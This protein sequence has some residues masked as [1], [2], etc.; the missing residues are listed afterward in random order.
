MAFLLLVQIGESVL[1]TLLAASFD[2]CI[3]LCSVCLNQFC[4]FGYFLLNSS[5]G[6]VALQNPLCYL[7]GR[8]TAGLRSRLL[9]HDMKLKVSQNL[10]AMGVTTHKRN[11]NVTRTL[12]S[13]IRTGSCKCMLKL[14]Q[15]L[16]ADMIPQNDDAIWLWERRCKHVVPNTLPCKQKV[17]THTPMMQ[18]T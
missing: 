18:P 11:C 8:C 12:E 10:K 4:T 13:L 5:F 15:H 16:Y 14:L 1:E 2:S 6:W 9:R 7:L 3:T 17:C